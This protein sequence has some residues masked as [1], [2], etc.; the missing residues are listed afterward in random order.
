MDYQVRLPLYLSWK[1]L[2]SLLGWPLSRVQTWRLMFEPEYR[3]RRFPQCRKLGP[4]RNSRPVWYT[5]DVL[6]YFKQHGLPV[7]EN[8]VFSD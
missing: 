6:G 4:Y 5:P 3:D 1:A 8:I 7:P 2:K